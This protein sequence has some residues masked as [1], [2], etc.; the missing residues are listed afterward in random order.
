MNLDDSW[1]FL[2]PVYFK[3]RG[4][5]QC[6]GGVPFIVVRASALVGE[7]CCRIVRCRAPFLDAAC[8]VGLPAW[9]PFPDKAATPW[10]LSTP[11]E[12]DLGFGFRSKSRNASEVNVAWEAREAKSRDT[13]AFM[14]TGRN[15]TQT[16]RRTI[17]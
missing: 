1:G 12:E 7:V 3:V 6:V 13:A 2:G 8:R 11:S 4:L 16:E 17:F 10:F 15:K 14:P 9:V 5:P